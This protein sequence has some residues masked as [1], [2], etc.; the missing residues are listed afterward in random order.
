MK[1]AIKL[2]PCFLLLFALTFINSNIF[3]QIYVSKIFDKEIILGPENVNAYNE[4]TVINHITFLEDFI[5]DLDIAIEKKQDIIDA[6]AAKKRLKKREQYQLQKAQNAKR[7]INNEKEILTHFILMWE[8]ISTKQKKLYEIA[9]HLDQ[10]KCVEFITKDDILF[11]QELELRHDQN[12]A[13]NTYKEVIPVTHI[14]ASTKWVKKRADRNCLSANPDDCLVW[15]LIEIKE[16]Y[17][18]KDLTFEEF[19]YDGCPDSFELDRERSECFRTF[20]TED[21]REILPNLS[22]RKKEGKED[23]EVLEWRV[24]EC[25]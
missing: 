18:F 1:K 21:D 14:G 10:A 20:K 4:S 3:A 6:F 13:S 17:T 16:G 7:D 9:A 12:N 19:S 15:C 22:L 24:V 23:V 11:N 8:N 5:V 2:L 25:N